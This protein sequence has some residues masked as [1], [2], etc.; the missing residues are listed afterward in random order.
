M[1]K[2]MVIPAFI[3]LTS[4]GK[5]TTVEGTVYSKHLFPVAN[6]TIT[7]EMFKGSDYPDH[8]VVRLKTNVDGKYKTTFR[9]KNQRYYEL[10]CES[11]SGTM[12]GAAIR[13]GVSSTID[14]YMK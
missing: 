11:D 14:I 2:Y 8:S 9:A 6:A 10:Y 12:N 4:C 7:V 3:L 5:R 1:V 13:E